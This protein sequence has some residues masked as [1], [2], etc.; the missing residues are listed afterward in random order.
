[1]CRCLNQELGLV[2]A[3]ARTLDER[4]KALGY[5]RSC[6]TFEVAFMLHLMKDILRITYDQNISG[7]RKKEQDIAN[8][9]ILLE[10]AENKLQML[11]VDGWDPLKD[12]VSTFCIKHDILIPNFDEPYANFGRP[13]RKVVGHI[14]LYHYR[15]DVFYKIIDW[16]LQKFNDCFNEGTN[17]LFNGVACLNSFDSFSKFNIRK[18]V[19]MAKLYLDDFDEFSLGVLEN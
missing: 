11:R 2:K 1:M 18:I 6:Q 16:Q 4:A 10:V 12:K 17:Y 5:L 13:R 8:S 14:T 7:S 9:M 19:K 3:D 15:V